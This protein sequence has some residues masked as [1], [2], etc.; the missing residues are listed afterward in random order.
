MVSCKWC[1]QLPNTLFILPDSTQAYAKAMAKNI[2]LL[3]DFMVYWVMTWHI[4]HKK[5]MDGNAAT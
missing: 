3:Y 4:L 1:W 2:A 5:M